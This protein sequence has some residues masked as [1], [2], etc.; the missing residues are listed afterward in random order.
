MEIYPIAITVP[1]WPTFTKACEKAMG[2][3]PTRKLDSEK[4]I[5]GTPESFL[6]SLDSFKNNESNIREIKNFSCKHINVSFLMIL[7]NNLYYEIL[8][9]LNQNLAII[10]SDNFND[11]NQVAIIL[12]GS[13]LEWKNIC[14]EANHS[15]TLREFSYK[16]YELLRNGG[17]SNIFNDYRI[18]EKS[19]GSKL[20][21]R[22]Y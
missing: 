11:K 4:L 8:E 13:L 20:F 19:D 3:N 21:E 16:I 12:T 2:Y 10:R 17:Y 6:M 9:N 5:V 18:I 15:F 7:E 1:N 22:R 14:I